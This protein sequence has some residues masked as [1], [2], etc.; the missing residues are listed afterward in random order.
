[1]HV[2]M[3]L[4]STMK[5]VRPSHVDS[6]G[7][8]ARPTLPQTGFGSL[9]SKHDLHLLFRRPRLA[10]GSLHSRF[11]GLLLF[12]CLSLV[13]DVGASHGPG[14]HELFFVAIVLTIVPVFV[15]LV[16]SAHLRGNKGATGPVPD[17]QTVLSKLDGPRGPAGRLRDGPRVVIQVGTQRKDRFAIPLVLLFLKLPAVDFNVGVRCRPVLALTGC[18]S[19]VHFPDRLLGHLNR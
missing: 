15:K 10:F 12:G 2:N 17:G 7:M 14:P 13:A 9:L 18:C 5:H 11:T 19:L 8:R 3:L 1:M 4:K 6:R 16:Y